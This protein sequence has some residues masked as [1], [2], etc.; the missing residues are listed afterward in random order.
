MLRRLRIG[1]S[2][3]PETVTRA[4]FWRAEFR[5]RVDALFETCDVVLTPT[6]PVDVPRR[7]AVDLAASTRD[8]ARFCYVWSCYGGPAVSVPAGTHP[9]SGMPVGLQLT[10]APWRDDVLAWAAARVADQVAQ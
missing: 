6:I 4:R 3:A 9:G 1:E 2:I 8:I 5:R 10:A 7:D